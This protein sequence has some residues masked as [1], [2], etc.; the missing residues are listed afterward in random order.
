MTNKSLNIFSR[1]RS[2]ISK[3]L[4]L[5]MNIASI[6]L[7]RTNIFKSFKLQKSTKLFLNSNKTKLFF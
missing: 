4:T 7:L 2:L 5:G 1:P 3:Y 6:A